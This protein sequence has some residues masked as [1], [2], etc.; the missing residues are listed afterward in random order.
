MSFTQTMD[1]L[2]S[3]A[4]NTQGQVDQ[5]P[6]ESI[7][8]GKSTTGGVDPSA[9]R[10]YYAGMMY[11]RFRVKSVSVNVRPK[12][13]PAASGV[14]NY[15]FYGAWDR[16]HDDILSSELGPNP[17]IVT[18]DPSCKMIIWSPG[19]SAGGLRSYVYSVPKDRYQYLGINHG[20]S[21]SGGGWSVYTTRDTFY[22]IYRFVL[23]AGGLRP[24]QLDIRL[25]FQFR[26][27]LEFSGAA[28]IA[29]GDDTGALPISGVT[30]I[31]QLNPPVSDSNAQIS[32]DTIVASR[33][34][35]RLPPLNPF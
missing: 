26:Y 34:R 21:S 7:L 9:G 6:M 27:T 24:A 14:P 35:S 17:R 28:S 2:V 33:L 15:T 16:Y 30:S 23:D 3:I 29:A 18:D 13:M 32:E 10:I 11:D 19:G 8:S 1:R 20:I 5:I 22:P 12:I 4:P 31:R 25:I